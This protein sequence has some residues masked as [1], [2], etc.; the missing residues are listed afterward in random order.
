MILFELKCV[1]YYNYMEIKNY[2]QQIKWKIGI[3]IYLMETQY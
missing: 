1:D 3:V 2:Y